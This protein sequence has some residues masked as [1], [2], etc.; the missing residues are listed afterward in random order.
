MFHA[1][2]G[3]VPRSAGEKNAGD[4]VAPVSGSIPVPRPPGMR[5]R[6]FTNKELTGDSPLAV[7]SSST[8]SND[9][10]TPQP[11]N[12]PSPGK[13]TPKA[14]GKP[15][16]PAEIMPAQPTDATP[17]QQQFGL[18]TGLL[19][20]ESQ[21]QAAS[22]HLPE[23][24]APSDKASNYNV[25]KFSTSGETLPPG[26]FTSFQSQGGKVKSNLPSSLLP[27]AAE[28]SHVR[29][30]AHLGCPPGLPIPFHERA[31]DHES[32]DATTGASS[33]NVGKTSKAVD[34][35]E[36]KKDNDSTNLEKNDSFFELGF[37]R[38]HSAVKSAPPS[39]PTDLPPP[40]TAIA[41][42]VL[43]GTKFLPKIVLD[44][45]GD[46][47]PLNE[48]TT[49]DSPYIGYLFLSTFAGPG[50]NAFHTGTPRERRLARIAEIK[51]PQRSSASLAEA[52]QSQEFCKYLI[53]HLGG[54]PGCKARGMDI[55][56]FNC[57]PTGTLQ[58]HTTGSRVSKRLQRESFFVQLIRHVR[59]FGV[60]DYFYESCQS[61]RALYQVSQVPCLVV[62][63]RADSMVMNSNALPWIIRDE[64]GTC[65]PWSVC[66]TI[67]NEYDSEYYFSR[68]V[69]SGTDGLEDAERK[70]QEEELLPEKL[71]IK[72]ER[73]EKRAAKYSS[74]ISVSRQKRQSK[75]SA[76]SK[77]VEKDRV[78][79]KESLFSSSSEEH[80]ISTVVVSGKFKGNTMTGL[81]NGAESLAKGRFELGEDSIEKLRDIF[82]LLD[83]D[84]DGK[85]EED[86]LLTA[87][88]AV[89]IRP[90]R[91]IKFELGKRLRKMKPGKSGIGFKMFTRIIRATLIA[92]PTAVTEIDSLSSLFESEQKPGIIK[93]HELR[94]L[95]SGVQT[96]SNTQLSSSE[97]EILFGNLGIQ[98][99]DD[100][101]L[102]EYVDQV[103]GDLI[104]VVDHRRLRDQGARSWQR[105]LSEK[106]QP[107][108][109]A[110][111][112]TIASE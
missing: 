79:R 45:H 56:A 100:V 12:S 41:G 28:K 86:Q 47:L 37:K 2:D 11:L 24:S 53:D 64:N 23:H 111:V 36:P 103:G 43:D 108:P 48:F 31:F 70:W 74:A 40:T 106:P 104:R 32:V 76:K 88:A 93:G 65:F 110:H 3:Q 80:S 17:P 57:G 51:H 107:R 97:A 62:V 60:P 50:S 90:T 81:K 54:G 19:L 85:L 33:D 1:N 105:R 22:K 77:V 21:T 18:P 102:H 94:H 14:N 91:R 15:T 27:H 67:G 42:L 30:A 29:D 6:S 46:E 8:R 87:F 5:R 25:A 82:H 66:E 92:Q 59:C 26:L 55:I 34:E 112:E 95:L 99:K 78:R 98:D 72:K 10:Q 89:G 61:L 84:M 39:L 75:P 7:L 52:A 4:R 13:N 96:S 69:H 83:K 20:P 109:K 58:S 73:K 71:L 16:P 38:K 101:H 63:R 68:E 49:S 9:R 35:V 44:Y